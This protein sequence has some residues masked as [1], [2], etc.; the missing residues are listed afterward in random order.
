MAKRYTPATVNKKPKTKRVSV[1][2]KFYD[3]TVVSGND[4]E[5]SSIARHTTE[6]DKEMDL[7]ARRVVQVAVSDAKK[8]NI[9][10]GKYDKKRGLAYLEY[11]DGKREYE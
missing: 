6:S 1:G 5:G 2:G 10:I 4:A 3:V 7:R 8:N 9:P 11:P